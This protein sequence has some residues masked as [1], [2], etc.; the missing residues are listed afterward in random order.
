MK[1]QR[2]FTGREF[3]F[4]KYAAACSLDSNVDVIRGHAGAT[5]PPQRI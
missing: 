1:S 4:F 5:T 3:F 2:L